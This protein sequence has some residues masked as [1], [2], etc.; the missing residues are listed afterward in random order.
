MTTQPDVNLLSPDALLTPEPLFAELR[1]RC[2]VFHEESTDTYVLTRY[3][4]V[5]AAAAQPRVF[6]NE[7]ATFAE[8]DPEI[9]AIQAEGFPETAT[10]TASDPPVHTRYRKLV[11]RAFSPAQVAALEPSIRAVVRELLDKITAKGSADFVHEFAELIPGYVIADALGVDRA[12]QGLF[13][14]WIDDV[15]ES[16]QSPD[17]LTRDRRLACARGLVEFQHYIAREVEKRRASQG[18][19]LISQLVEARV[20]GE[21]PLEIPEIIDFVR[22]LLVAGNE[23]TAAWIAGTMKLLLDHPDALAAVTADPTRI[24]SMLEESLRLITPSR[25][26]RRSVKVEGAEVC[27]VDLPAAA[28]MRLVWNAANRDER[29]FDAPEEFRIDR[30][31]AN[32]HLAFGHGI[33]HCLGAHLARAEARITF[34]EVL[35]RLRGFALTVPTEEV[36]NVPMAGVNRLQSLPLTYE[37]VP[38]VPVG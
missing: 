34:E 37:Q 30:A 8:I 29:R 17:S 9:A 10:L 5:R 32:Q 24:P 16:I 36:R 25:W 22:I 33:H 26:N 38:G 15:T 6:S 7:R 19:D 21:Q 35:A 1:D 28:K 3:E 4:D 14:R 2:P 18:T 31:D 27:G 11:N 20:E 23:T 12:D 13:L